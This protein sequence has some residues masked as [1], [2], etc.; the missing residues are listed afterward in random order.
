MVWYLLAF[1]ILALVLE[2]PIVALLATL[3]RKVP[4]PPPLPQNYVRVSMDRM[5]RR[6]MDRERREGSKDSPSLPSV[7]SW[8]N[9]HKEPPR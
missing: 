3:P 4:P 2:K 6:K 1:I 8:F 5:S 9:T 7:G